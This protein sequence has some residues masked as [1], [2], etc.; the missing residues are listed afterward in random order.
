ME[1]GK[2][3]DRSYRALLAREAKYERKVVAALK[4]AL[5]EMRDEMTVIY[6]KYAADG[7]LS[8]ADM[9]RYN[10]LRNLE[11][12]ILQSMDAATRATLGTI[13]TL[14]PEQYGESF[15]HYAWAVDQSTGVALRWGALNRDAIV[16]SLDNTMYKIAA[17]QYRSDARRRILRALNSGL[18]Q[19]KS[20]DDMARHLRDAIN[21]TLFQARR[22]IR[23]EG[24]TAIQAGADAAYTRAEEQGVEM[25]IIWDATLDDAT[26]PTHGAMDGAVRGDDGLFNGPGGERAPYPGWEGL[27]AGERINCRCNLRPEIAGYSPSLRRTRDGGVVPYQTYDEWKVSHSTWR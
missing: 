26:R 19:G 14:K 6:G 2:L 1:L 17:D 12:D 5:A 3:A 24:Q 25:S 9:T 4:T 7:A 10:R 8:L 16:A 13:R 23:T 21:T 27:S 20:Y 22:I 15:F 11:T 18:A